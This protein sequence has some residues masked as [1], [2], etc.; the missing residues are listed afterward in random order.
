[1][2]ATSIP[3][4]EASFFKYGKDSFGKQ[5]VLTDMSV[6]IKGTADEMKYVECRR[7]NGDETYFYHEQF[8]K[9]QIVLHFTA[10]YLKGDVGVLSQH[11]WHVSVPF[12]LARNGTILNMWSSA[13]WSYHLGKG[14]VGG[15]TTNS[16][17]TIAIEISNIGYLK[18]VGNNL[19]TSYAN[20]DIY[21]GLDQTSY[22][23]KLDVPYRDEE[24]Y[25]TFTDAQYDSLIVLLR[26]LTAQY[27]IPKAF[28]PEPK[29]YDILTESE[30]ASFRG[31][32]SHVNYR[33]SGKWDIG[34]A[35]D[36]AR[37]ISGLG[38]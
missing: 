28:L 29:R 22:Y 30:V 9:D 18:K 10:G 35:F 21:C 34:P 3:N 26:Y 25:A 6:P 8:A 15:N 2:K 27:N 11:N 7:D 38:A 17:R 4:H 13:A 19:V 14:A 36:W 1:M 20:T 31:I 23:E 5:F 24:Y 12:I 33:S 16:K 37:V 32:V